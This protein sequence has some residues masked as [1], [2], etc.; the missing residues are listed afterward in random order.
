MSPFEDSPKEEAVFPTLVTDCRNA[1]VVLGNSSSECVG[2]EQRGVE[3]GL[4][5]AWIM[6]D[7][8][9]ARDYVGKINTNSVDSIVL[10]A[11][12]GLVP[13]AGECDRQTR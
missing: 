3:I 2:T 13:E 11:Q 7:L 1:G 5:V 10:D 6:I 12:Q 4:A 8:K 9:F